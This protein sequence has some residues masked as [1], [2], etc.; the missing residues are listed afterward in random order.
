MINKMNDFTFKHSEQPDDL[1]TYLT[2]AQVKEK[3]DSRGIELRT[4]LN[5]LIDT[6]Q[7]EGASN[8]YAKPIA[9]NSGDTI[10]AQLEWLL[11]QIAVAAT[12][13]IPDGTLGETKLTPELLTKINKSLS[14]IGVL[15]TL[16]TEDKSSVVNA[17]NENKSLLS[18]IPNQT[19]IIDKAKKSDLDTTNSNLVNQNRMI[20][21]GGMV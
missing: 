11:S 14:N 16:L 15:T 12:G 17:I 5:N 13:A 7:L 9:V 3:F 6:L 10:Q 21:M 2:S 8:I 20:S 4:A 1:Y 19:Y 18:D